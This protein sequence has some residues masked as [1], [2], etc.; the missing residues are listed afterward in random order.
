MPKRHLNT[1]LLEKLVAKTGKPKQ[2]LREQIS[3]K[4]GKLARRLIYCS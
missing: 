4:A 3:R 1:D 2:Y